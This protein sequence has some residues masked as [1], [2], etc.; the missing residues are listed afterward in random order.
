M[1]RAEMPIF[2]RTFDL[3]SWLLP[4]SNQLPKAHRHDFTRRML[5]AAFDLREALEDANVRRAPVTTSG[6]LASHPVALPYQLA[7]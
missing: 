3:L 2:S 1:A 4:A 5:D 7:P 6:R